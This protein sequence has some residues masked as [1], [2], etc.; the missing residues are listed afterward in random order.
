[1]CLAWLTTEKEKGF[2]IGSVEAIDLE[3]H[4]YRINFD[5][6]GVGK[7][8]V[9]DYNTKSIFPVETIS[10]SSLEAAHNNRQLIPSASPHSSSLSLP[11][12]QPPPRLPMNHE[13]LDPLLASIPTSRRNN[14]LQ[15]ANSL[16]G[17]PTNFLRQ[18]VQMSKL[19]SLKQDRLKQLASLNTDAEKMHARCIPLS[20]DFQKRYATVVID[21]DDLNLQLNNKSESI[22]KYTNEL[23]YQ[24]EPHPMSN[25]QECMEHASVITDI[26]NVRL[27]A[28]GSEVTDKNIL[29]I[30]AKLTSILLQVEMLSQEGR[31]HD[32]S[33]LQTT[34]SE[35]ASSIHPDNQ[36]IFLKHIETPLALIQSGMDPSET[37]HPFS[38]ANKSYRTRTAPKSQ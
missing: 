2:Y 23:G 18:V 36:R 35:V 32:L 10:L 14:D 20:P 7:H 17:F 30:I 16:G 15:T 6:P 38:V 34:I 22:K 28:S 21:L 31:S 26:S 5:K 37:L 27:R 11:Y 9:F 3:R 4:Q 19:L 8:S 24:D 25:M 13:V 29:T 1:L 12:I 33:D